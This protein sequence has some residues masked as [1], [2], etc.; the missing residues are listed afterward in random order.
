MSLTERIK[1]VL[2]PGESEPA[3]KT[4]LAE[5]GALLEAQEKASAAAEQSLRLS[6]NVGASLTEQRSAIDAAADHGRL[7]LSRS[8]DAKTTAQQVQNALER[9]KLIALNAGLEGSRTEGGGG[10]ALLIVSEELRG[11]LERGTS[12]AED[13]L[14]ALTQMEREREKL[15]DQL[16]RAREQGNVLA[17]E[18]LRSQNLQRVTHEQLQQLGQTLTRV[19]GADPELGRLIVSAQTHARGLLEALTS[20]SNKP[21]RLKWLRALGPSLTPLLRM[22]G[23]QDDAAQKNADEAP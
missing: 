14:T 19:T 6:E 5:A 20:L 1:N 7:L 12:A 11:V 8:R 2:S 17:D 15:R 22:L 21:G 13:H 4:P 23:D 16:E 9:A 3:S 18:L 10:K